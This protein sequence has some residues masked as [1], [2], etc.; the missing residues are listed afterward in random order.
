MVVLPALVAAVLTVV[1]AQVAFPNGSPNADEIAYEIQADA[2][3]HGHLTLPAESHDPSFLPMMSGVRD[4]RVVFKYQPVWP[5]L[6]AASD[7]AFGSTLPLRALLAAAAVLA[8]YALARSLFG[9]SKTAL[10]AATLAALSPFVWVQSATLLG[11]QLSFVLGTACAAALITAVRD[12]HRGWALGAGLLFGLALLHRP[13]DAVLA[14]LPVLVYAV[15]VTRRNRTAR[16]VLVPTAIGVLPSALAL[17]ALNTATMGAPWRM[18]FNVSG[19]IDRF[20]FGWRASFVVPG[21]GH[22]GQVHYTIGRAVTT[23]V[24]SVGALPRFVCAAP[25]VFGLAIWVSARARRDTRVQLLVAMIATTLF[26]YLFWW[27]TANA[28]AFGLHEV[29]GP[30]YHYAVLAPIVVLAARGAV[31]LAE[32]RGR[33]AVVAVLA[34]AWMVPASAVA[35]RNTRVAGRVRTEHL[36]L[37]DA[38]GRSMVLMEPRFRGE[39]YTPLVNDVELTGNRIVAI[40]IPRERLALIDRFPDRDAYLIRFVHG[41]GDPFGPAYPQQVRLSVVAADAVEISESAVIAPGREARAYIH[42]GDHTVLGPTATGHLD[43]SFVIEP[44][45]LGDGP[46]LVSVG[47]SIGRV[48]QA[49]PAAIS[50]EWT[51]CRFV[52]ARVGS[53]VHVLTPCDGFVNYVFDGSSGAAHEDLRGALDITVAPYAADTIG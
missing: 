9:R 48:A 49:A 29:L 13:F 24:D 14:L 36:A 25:I 10:I 15:L 19:P 18:P 30:F 23:L 35:V 53:E 7:A 5:A 11:Y 28:V 1:V 50:L 43:A 40:D 45:Q 16:R 31:L 2:I 33:A 21:T 6:M 39:P 17:G 38:P 44:E 32:R 22:A 12:R 8:V 51:E 46:V 41:P 47:Y 20:G 42:I 27:G 37:A 4:G 3:R 52:A 26:A 34:I